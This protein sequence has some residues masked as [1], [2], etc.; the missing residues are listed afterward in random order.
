M[1]SHGFHFHLIGKRPFARQDIFSLEVGV[2]HQHRCGVVIHIPYQNRHLRKPC[3]FSGMSTAVSGNDFV[4]AMIERS[5]NQWS[6]DTVF[7]DAFRRSQHSLII[8][9]L[10]RVIFEGNQ[11]TNRDILHA[12][13]LTFCA[14]FIRFE[15]VIVTGQ[16][17]VFA[18]FRHF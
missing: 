8:E 16:A 12:L 15:E 17:D 4:S 18:F 3:Q 2:Y 11:F 10:E 6:Q 7:C 5:G 14:A 1:P 13:Q 9:H